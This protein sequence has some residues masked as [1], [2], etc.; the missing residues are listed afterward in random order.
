MEIKQTILGVNHRDVALGYFNN[1][2]LAKDNNDLDSTVVNLK[3]AIDIYKVP[4]NTL[5]VRVIYKTLATSL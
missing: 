4:Q 5:Y 2:N 3:K 1:A